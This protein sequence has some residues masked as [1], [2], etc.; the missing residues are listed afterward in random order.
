MKKF[1][2]LLFVLTLSLNAVAFAADSPVLTNPPVVTDVTAGLWG[3]T[4]YDE[5]S[6]AELDAVAQSVAEGKTELEHFALSEEDT[7]KLEALGLDLAALSVDELLHVTVGGYT[8][9]PESVTF[10]ATFT[11]PYEVGTKVAVLMG[12]GAA[13]GPYQWTAEEGVVNADG[14]VTVTL[15]DFPDEP[16]LLAILS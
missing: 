4:Q 10:K 6:Q 16:F 14:T 8:E 1:L 3:I 15:T 2:A 12:V 9:K 7:A 11:V 5:Q 13:P